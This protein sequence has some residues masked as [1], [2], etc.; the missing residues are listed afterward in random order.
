MTDF[1]LKRPCPKCPFV[2]GNGYLRRDRARQIATDIANGA[3]FACHQTTTYNDETGEMESLAESQF[4]AGALI[5]MEKQNA[6]NQIMRIAERLGIYDPSALDMGASVCG[7]SLEFIHQHGDDSAT[8]E[9]ETCSIANAGCLAP[10][11]MLV[12]GVAIDCEPEGE[13]GCC[14]DCGEPVCENCAPYCYCKESD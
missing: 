7:S 11:G 5:M 3:T 14:E 2:K 9:Q 12:G 10:A 8:E 6:P 13:V 4:C 1:K